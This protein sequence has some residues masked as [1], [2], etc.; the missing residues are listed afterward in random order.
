MTLDVVTNPLQADHV[1]WIIVCTKTQDTAS[2][3]AW[4]ER[5]CG[6]DTCVAVLQN[7]IEHEQRVAPYVGNRAVVPAVVYFNGERRSASN[8]S[9]RRASEDDISI[10]DTATGQAFAALFEGALLKV[11]PRQDFQQRL[12]AKLLLNAVANPITA[13]TRQRL[14]VFQRDDVRSIASDIIRE[15]LA[16]ALAGGV[17]LNEKTQSQVLARLLSYHPDE[18]TSMYFDNVNGRVLEVD[19]LT[20]AI[21]R[22]GESL[23]VPTPMN[24]ILLVLLQAI[25]DAAK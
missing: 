7:G 4:F 23:G 17:D 11:A 5:L 15:G 18:A 8:F 24:R 6:P 10:P 19:A 16:V 22:M 1:D 12:W 9:F 25:S 13:L 20:G 2:A 21:V 3:S 14:A